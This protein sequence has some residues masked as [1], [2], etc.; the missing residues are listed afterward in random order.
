MKADIVIP[1]RNS[2]NDDEELRYALRSIDKYYEHDRIFI[3][4]QKPKW[5]KN[6]EFIPCE[7]FPQRESSIVNKILLACENGVSE[8]FVRWD[9]DHFALQPIEEIKYWYKN[10]LKEWS[11]YKT[12]RGFYKDTVLNTIS[13]FGEGNYFD[14]HVPIVFEREKFK[15]TMSFIRT[16]RPEI[17]CKTSYCYLNKIEGEEFAWKDLVIMSRDWVR[18]VIKRHIEG[19]MFFSVGKDGMSVDMHTVLNSL[20]PKKSKYE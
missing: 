9:D 16:E 19:R 6:V 8:K 12:V 17:L 3:V 1:Y 14:I 4:G 20:Y 18:W 10:N 13:K 11:E 15:E 7:D 2:E 5:L